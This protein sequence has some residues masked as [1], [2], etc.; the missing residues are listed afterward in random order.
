M[1]GEFERA[2]GDEGEYEWSRPSLASDPSTVPLEQRHT[3]RMFVSIEPRW[4][5]LVLIEDAQV[6]SASPEARRIVRSRG[7]RDVSLSIEEAE[8]LLRVLPIALE[9]L[10]AT[11]S[12]RASG[13]EETDGTEG[14]KP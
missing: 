5:E 4:S 13:T 1:S 11:A 10:R 2:V 3:Y 6:T 14:W 9:R 8:W 12:T 7:N